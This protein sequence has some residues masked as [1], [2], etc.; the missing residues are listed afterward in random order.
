[1]PE[2]LPCPFCGA[3]PEAETGYNGHGHTVSCIND[4]CP[5]WLVET[6][7]YHTPELAAERWNSRPVLACA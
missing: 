5:L 1:M 7:T 6:A 2:L 4:E 3:P